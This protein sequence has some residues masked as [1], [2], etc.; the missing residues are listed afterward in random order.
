MSLASL[1]GCAVAKLPKRQRSHVKTFLRKVTVHI[2]PLV[3]KSGGKVSKPKLQ[4]Q[5]VVRNELEGMDA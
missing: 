4:I 2:E 5:L 1:A 3:R